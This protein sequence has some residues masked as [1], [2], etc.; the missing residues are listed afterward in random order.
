LYS[1]LLLLLLQHALTR[2]HIHDSSLVHNARRM[3]LFVCNVQNTVERAVAVEVVAADHVEISPQIVT[4]SAH[5][6]A[7]LTSDKDA[8]R[9]ATSAVVAEVAEVVVVVSQVALAKALGYHQVHHVVKSKSVHQESLLERMQ[10][11]EHGHGKL[12]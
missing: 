11:L 3:L 8:Q 1:L 12:P 5:G 4:C 10:K 9:P 2:V 7:T 6:V